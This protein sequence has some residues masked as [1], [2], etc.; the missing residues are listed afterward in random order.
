MLDFHILG[1]S[2]VAIL[3]DHTHPELVGTVHANALKPC[4]FPVNTRTAVTVTI[5]SIGLL[6]AEIRTAGFFLED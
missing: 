1:M 2:F 3:S 4:R 5:T 6:Y